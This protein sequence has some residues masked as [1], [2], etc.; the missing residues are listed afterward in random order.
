V[1]IMETHRPAE[2]PAALREEIAYILK[3]AGQR[4]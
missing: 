2:P 4:K 1:E 3:T